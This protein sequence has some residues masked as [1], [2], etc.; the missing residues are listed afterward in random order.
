MN[1]RIFS[2][3]RIQRLRPSSFTTHLF[4]HFPNLSQPKF[5]LRSIHSPHSAAASTEPTGNDVKFVHPSVPPQILTQ[6][7]DESELSD[8]WYVDPTYATEEDIR[9]A[10]SLQLPTKLPASILD[11]ISHHLISLNAQNLFIIDM[12]KKCTW[13]RWMVITNGISP[14]HKRRIV[15]GLRLHLKHQ[16]IDCFLEGEDT[17]WTIVDAGDVLVHCFTESQRSFYDLESLWRY[18]EME[19]SR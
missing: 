9:P 5:Q 14:S 15:E 13:A 2:L 17:E 7:V 8:L 1:C 4:K 16:N 12:E 19:D 11:T 6:T 10:S 18:S 3:R